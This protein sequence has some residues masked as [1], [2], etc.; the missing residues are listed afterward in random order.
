M[1]YL[2]KSIY[3]QNNPQVVAILVLVYRWRNERHSVDKRVVYVSQLAS[4]GVRI[5]AQVIWPQSPHYS[6]LL[7]SGSHRGENSS[8]RSDRHG[9]ECRS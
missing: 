9:F 8:V 5:Q 3:A 7:F 1:L 4:G 6:R 2:Y